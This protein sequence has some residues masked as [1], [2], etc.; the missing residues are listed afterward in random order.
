MALALSSVFFRWAGRSVRYI[1]SVDRR[2]I[3]V[4]SLL[5]SG[6]GG[7]EPEVLLEP[8]QPLWFEDVTEE[9]GV[10]LVHVYAV[11][12]RFWMP[13]ISSG[14]LAFLDYDSDG[15]LDLYLVQ[16]IMQ[17]LLEMGCLSG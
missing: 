2:L 14:G 5:V 3:V 8:A 1:S 6:C 13:E 7:S 15:A 17:E 11:E 10:N 9:A 12:Q 4:S 16:S